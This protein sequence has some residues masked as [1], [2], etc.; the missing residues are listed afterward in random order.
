MQALEKEFAARTGYQGGQ[1][2]QSTM[3]EKEKPALTDKDCYQTGRA[4]AEAVF[5][6]NSEASREVRLKELK[7]ALRHEAEDRK[8]QKFGLAVVAGWLLVA[9][10]L[11]LVHPL[12]GLLLLGLGVWFAL[13]CA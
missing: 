11:C 3:I 7:E 8:A 4:L 10:G 12:L 5:G 2:P 13:G 9:F 1:R 6:P